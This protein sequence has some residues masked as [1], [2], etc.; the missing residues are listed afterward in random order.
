MKQLKTW[1]R[2]L[3]YLKNML[4]GEGETNIAVVSHS[5]YLGQMLNCKMENELKHCYPY[6]HKL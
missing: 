6:I 4:V 3:K 1:K 5:S 2:G